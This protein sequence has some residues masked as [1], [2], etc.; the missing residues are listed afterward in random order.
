M[1]KGGGQGTM[2]N[3]GSPT[4]GESVGFMESAMKR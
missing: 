2:D 3:P 4:G 1:N